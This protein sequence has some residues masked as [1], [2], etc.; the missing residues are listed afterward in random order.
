MSAAARILKRVIAEQEHASSANLSR[1]KKKKR[2][3]EYVIQ[4]ISWIECV[5]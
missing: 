1:L 3:V 5:P 4:G 2:Q